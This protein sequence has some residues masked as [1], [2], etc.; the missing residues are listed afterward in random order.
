MKAAFIVFLFAIAIQFKAVAQY[1]GQ[2]RLGGSQEP[3]QM[4]AQALA[5]IE[6]A[7]S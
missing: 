3:D 5:E 6:A 2:R 1:G 4:G 7:D